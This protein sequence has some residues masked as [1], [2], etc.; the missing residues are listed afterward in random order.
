V[1]SRGR[2]QNQGFLLPPPPPPKDRLLTPSSPLKTPPTTTTTKKKTQR[3]EF[4]RTKSD[5]VAKL[6]GTYVPDKDKRRAAVNAEKREGLIVR[7][8]QRRAAAAA[9]GGVPVAAGMAPP[10]MAAAAAPGAP[11]APAPPSPILFVQGLPE[12]TTAAMLAM[13]FK[14]FPGYKEARTVEARPGIAFVEFESSVQA[15]VALAG[16]QGFKVTPAH[17]MMLSYA[18]T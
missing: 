15:G 3:I 4:A 11:Q 2:E 6:D 5:A 18:R 16:L 9:A 14:Q 7:G 8:Q 10:A 1:R 13:L 12:A 17:A